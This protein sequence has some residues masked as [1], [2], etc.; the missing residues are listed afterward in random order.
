MIRHLTVCLMTL[1][2]FFGC[3]SDPGLKPTFNQGTR[4]GIVNSVEPVVT[5]RHITVRRINSFT[6]QIEVDWNIPGYLDERLTEALKQDSRFVVVP[7]KSAEILSRQKKLSESITFA[8]TRT[9]ISQDVTDYIESTAKAHDLD[10]VIVVQTFNGESPWRIY[11]DVIR[12]Q[13]YGLFTRRTMLGTVSLRSHWA[14]PYAQILVA[15]FKIQPVT[16]IG[17]GFPRLTRGRMDNFNW[18]A[19]IKDVPQAELD[20]LR[21]RIQEYAN[22]AVTNALRDAHMI[23][24]PGGASRSNVAVQRPRTTYNFISSSPSR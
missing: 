11:D 15:V 4:V 12:L 5:H 10:V 14:H 24:F 20:K 18:P 7:V 1:I 23:A 17:A 21:P 3:A 9:R 19:D 13:G 22:Q 8:A 2:L 6:K 16:R